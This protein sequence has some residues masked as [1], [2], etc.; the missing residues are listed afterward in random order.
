MAMTIEMMN[1][2]GDN[3]VRVAIDQNAVLLGAQEVDA[4]IERLSL[5]RAAMRP[6][7]PKEPS[8]THQYV[9]EMDPCWHTEKHPLYDGAVLFMRHTGLG[10][11]GFALPTPSLAKLNEALGKHLEALQTEEAHALM[12]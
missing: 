3:A 1:E 9:I 6:E 11:A 7:V 4:V 2:Y 8:R 10:W 12:N 5:I